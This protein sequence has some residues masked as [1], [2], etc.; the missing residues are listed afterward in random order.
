[1]WLIF[2]LDII[3]LPVII[4]TSEIINAY[5]YFG[6]YWYSAGPC[7]LQAGDAEL[8][9]LVVILAQCEIWKALAKIM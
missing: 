8:I 9:G 3:N 2:I 1:M 6:D 4:C 5:K 7:R